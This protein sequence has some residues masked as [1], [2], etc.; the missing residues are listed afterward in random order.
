MRENKNGC[1]IPR[2]HGIVSAVVSTNK[3]LIAGAAG[4]AVL[5]VARTAGTPAIVRVARGE[6]ERWRGLLEDDPEAAPLLALYWTEGARVTPQPPTQPW[7][8]AFVSWVA[9]E[10]NPGSLQPSSSHMG[11]AH[12]AARSG[13]QSG[14]YTA[15]RPED[16]RVKPGDILVK[17]RDGASPTFEELGSGEYYPTHGDIIVSTESGLA[18]GIG[19]NVGNSVNINEYDLDPSGRVAP[20]ERVFVVLRKS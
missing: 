9:N 15:L 3:W 13:S 4:V 5:L 19:G 16:V 18:L 20:S 1:A 7:S 17:G 10:A 2:R 6:L 8:A 11:Y 12:A 14:V